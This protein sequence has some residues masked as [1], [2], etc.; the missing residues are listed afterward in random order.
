MST[1][2]EVKN[3]NNI[4]QVND[5]LSIL[6]HIAQTSIGQYYVGTK[7]A[8]WNCSNPYLSKSTRMDVYLYALPMEQ[9]S[10]YFIGS[11]FDSPVYFFMNHGVVGTYE[12]NGSV[13]SA[14]GKVVVG[15][16]GNGSNNTL[17]VTRAIADA[18]KV[19]KASTAL[20]DI[21]EHGYGMQCYNPSGKVVFD[22]QKPPIIIKDRFLEQ[23]I[24]SNNVDTMWRS[25]GEGITF[26]FTQKTFN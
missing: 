4:L 10:V 25:I 17:G 7:R 24:N 18:F 21:N 12:S 11:T 8:G 3:D 22:A 14:T 23:N 20:G 19:Y 9:D 13:T 1:Y 6:S 5:E 15:I 26:T 16:A 2:L